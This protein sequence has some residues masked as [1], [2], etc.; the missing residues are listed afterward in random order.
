MAR[1]AHFG[2]ARSPTWLRTTQYRGPNTNTMHPN[3]STNNNTHKNGQAAPAAPRPCIRSSAP[4][5]PSP[6]RTDTLAGANRYHYLPSTPPVVVV[7]TNSSSSNDKDDD[8]DNG[9]RHETVEVACYRTC[10]FDIEFR[11]MQRRSGLVAMRRSRKVR[12]RRER[13]YLGEVFRL[14][15]ED[16]AGGDGEGE[17]KGEEEAGE[18]GGVGNGG[19]GA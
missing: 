19:Q 18:L 7:V 5:P 15:G 4:S 1:F 16:T 14:V 3:N 10:K 13:G 8:N 11:L 17:G 6:I 2:N 12:H 9:R